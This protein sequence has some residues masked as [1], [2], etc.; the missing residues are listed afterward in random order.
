MG[1]EK[2]YDNEEEDR[3]HHGFEPYF[4]VQV[5]DG[6]TERENSLNTSLRI[7][8]D[9]KS[10]SQSFIEKIELVARTSIY[11]Y[12]SSKSRKGKTFLQIHMNQPRYVSPARK[13]LEQG[14]A[15]LDYLVAASKRSNPMFYL[16]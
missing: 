2:Q 11:G 12:I 5:W 9:S 7:F 14:I 15:G 10:E 1:E 8:F 13:L 6:F 4:Y 3:R 16:L